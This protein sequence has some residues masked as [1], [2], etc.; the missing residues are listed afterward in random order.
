MAGNKVVS[1]SSLITDGFGLKPGNLLFFNCP[2]LKVG[3]IDVFDNMGFSPD[4]FIFDTFLH[5]SHHFF[6]CM[7]SFIMG[8]LILKTI[9]SYSPDE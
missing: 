5:Q 6:L 3:A 9:S 1:E 4:D 7:K 2:D 8:E